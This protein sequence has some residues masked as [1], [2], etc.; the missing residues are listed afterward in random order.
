MSALAAQYRMPILSQAWMRLFI[1]SR[2]EAGH[3]PGVQG[4]VCTHVATPHLGCALHHSDII[5]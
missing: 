4:A 5:V 2:H 3:A 1:A